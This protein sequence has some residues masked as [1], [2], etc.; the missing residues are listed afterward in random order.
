[1]NRFTLQGELVHRLPTANVK[2]HSYRKLVLAIGSSRHDTSSFP[3]STRAGNFQRPG[4]AV[5]GNRSLRFPETDGIGR[6][7]PRLGSRERS[8]ALAEVAPPADAEMQ[9]FK[10]E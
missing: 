1:M 5:P 2:A 6:Q 7:H 3:L 10:I 4:R 8:R 9:F